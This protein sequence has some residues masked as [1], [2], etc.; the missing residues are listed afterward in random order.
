LK[1]PDTVKEAPDI[2]YF[3]DI[4]EISAWRYIEAHFLLKQGAG[5]DSKML[6][7]GNNS[8]PIVEERLA[9]NLEAFF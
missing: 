4:N 9:N 8:W 3:R 5:G 6:L 7:Q 2:P 1:A